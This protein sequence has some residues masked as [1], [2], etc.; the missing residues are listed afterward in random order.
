MS[1]N[2]GSENNH[3]TSQAVMKVIDS[4]YQYH[5]D[6]IHKVS[7]VYIQT[8]KK[9]FDTVDHSNLFLK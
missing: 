4:I 9:A 1:I 6:D 7:M 3:S 2:L 8:Y 5:D